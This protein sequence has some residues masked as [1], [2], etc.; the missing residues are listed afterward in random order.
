MVEFWLAWF[1]GGSP[2]VVLH[3]HGRT[4]FVWK[5]LRVPRRHWLH[6][7]AAV[8]PSLSW[9]EQEVDDCSESSS[10]SSSQQP[11][12]AHNVCCLSLL[13]LCVVHCCADYVCILLSSKA[14]LAMHICIC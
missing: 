8:G 5:G 1:D 13:F 14:D 10:A 11:C 4:F 7:A 9:G 3:H 2:R 6:W 12:A